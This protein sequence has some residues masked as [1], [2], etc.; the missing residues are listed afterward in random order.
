MTGQSQQLEKLAAAL[1]AAQSDFPTVNPDGTGQVGS[2]R[3]YKYATLAHVIET[4]RPILAEHKLAIA[5][6]CEPGEAQTIRLTTTLMHDSGQYISGTA[7]LRLANDTPQGYGSAMTY[8]RRYSYA[9]ILG[10][11]TEDDDDGH[12]G[13][14][15]Q[16]QPAAQRQRS[17]R[18]PP[19][20]K[21]S[22]N[23]QSQQS[24]NGN[25]IGHL[26]YDLAKA[27]K[28]IIARLGSALKPKGYS[29]TADIEREMKVAKLPLTTTLAELVAKLPDLTGGGEPPT[30]R[31]TYEPSEADLAFYGSRDAA[32]TAHEREQ[33]EAQQPALAAN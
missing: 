10:I 18:Q 1:A 17:E 15:R 3:Q 31:A 11:A 12:E 5:Q 25:A 32:I 23:G 9:A 16:A 19:A 6:T 7:V 8:A 24:D 29:G 33:Q 2:N 27:D 14:Q 13:S 20:A 26:P 22:A 28:A 21:S 4:V 30:E